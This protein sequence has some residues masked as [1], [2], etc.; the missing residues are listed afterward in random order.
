MN[1]Q[2]QPPVSS[3]LND[4]C[5][6]HSICRQTA[7]NEVRRGRLKLRKIGSRSIVTRDDETKWLES[8]PVL[9]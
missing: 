7:Y 8:L 4:F 1:N 5:K 6:R 9:A 3:T 2:P